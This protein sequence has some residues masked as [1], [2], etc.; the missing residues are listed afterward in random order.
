V[1]GH[2]DQCR[3]RI[4][5][6]LG[7]SKIEGILLS[8]EATEL[9]RYRIPTPRDDYPATIAAVVDLTARLMQG[10]TAN[11]TIGVAVPGSISPHTGLM[12]NA[13]STWLNGQP[14]DHDL[15]A[16]LGRPVRLANDANC[17][18]LSEAIDGAA[19]NA[20]IVFGVILGTGC[21]GGLVVN[22][23]LLDGPRGIGG[24][25][26]HNPLPSMTPDEYPGPSC[27]CGRKGCLETWVSGPG[28][29][30]DHA[31]VTG[32]THTA[33]EIAARAK[34][35]NSAAKATLSR[36][37]DRL[38]RG[39]AHVVNIVDPEVLVLGGGL[40][41]LSHLYEVLP[42]LMVSHIF[43]D[44]GSVVIKA[45][46]WGDASGSRGAARLWDVPLS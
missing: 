43:A 6:D 37:G 14:F 30:A 1:T 10:I 45:P 41:Q 22:G 25:W 18:A 16:A 36:H 27:W 7:G 28:M 26:G 24:E 5:L 23:R 12:Q 3:L 13:N 17:F 8:P 31:R 39:L 34:A 2:S 29:A 11:A 46:K 19:E 38:A 9:A 20:R 4:G 15:A 35:G 32:E 40:S 44:R 33:V 42:P 21:G